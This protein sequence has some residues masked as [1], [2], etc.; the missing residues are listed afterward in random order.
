MPNPDNVIPF[1][2]SGSVQEF[3][4]RMQAEGYGTT[5]ILAAAQGIIGARVDPD[6]FAFQYTRPKLLRAGRERRCFVV[7]LDLDDVK[8]PIWR[9]LRVASDLRLSHLH[10]VIQ[11][12]MGWTDSHLHHFQMGPDSK[13]FRMRPFLTPFDL[14]EGEDDGILES[15]V[16]LDQVIGKPG[17]RLFY[18][19]DFGDAWHHTVKL[20]KVEPWTDGD[21]VAKCVT[22]RRACP[23]EDVGGV[24]GYAELLDALDGRIEPGHEEWMAQVLE[25]LP[26]GFDPA[27][28]DVDEVNELLDRGPF[29]D[30]DLWHPEVAALLARD[31]SMGSMGLSLLLRQALVDEGE[32]EDDQADALTHR[33]RVLLRT[34]GA[35]LKLTA[36]GY[37]PPAVVLALYEELDLGNEWIGKGNRE[38]QTLPVLTLRESATA[39][40]L[41]R[42]ANGRLSVTKA[43]SKLADDPRA[44]LDHIR[45][46]IPLGRGFERD[47]GMLLLLFAAAGQDSWQARDEAGRIAG[48]LGWVSEG[49]DLGISFAHSVHATA[50]VLN[51]LCGRMA[52]PEA[53]AAARALLRRA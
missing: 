1:P 11:D 29:P 21:P 30:L 24:G 18:E 40:G 20:E 51:Q 52:G 13:D 45:S 39:L 53:R 3:L 43:G 23:P 46:R 37:L 4:A 32:P 38:D 28:F 31:R 8:P 19:Y 15:D 9:R 36:A 14:E 25:W 47:A 16:R 33:Y 27:A 12:A 41:L 6:R 7:R 34:V 5:D 48:G 17:Q 2:A 44:L 22:G 49:G 42:K 35:G 50:D 26:E 10:D